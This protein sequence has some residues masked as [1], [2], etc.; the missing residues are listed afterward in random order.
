VG[1]GAVGFIWIAVLAALFW[2]LLIRPQRRARQQA[3]ALQRSLSAGDEVVTVGGIIGTIVAM[4]DDTVDLD[5]ADDVVMTV[6][7]RAIVG[8]AAPPSGWVDSDE[9]SDEDEADDP[10]DDADV[11]LDVAGEPDAKADDKPA[12]DPR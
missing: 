5:V 11:P 3:A 7:R 8:P 4:D 6:T 10:D 2:L 9:D 12:D 1:G